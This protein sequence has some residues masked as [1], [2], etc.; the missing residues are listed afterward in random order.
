LCGFRRLGSDAALRTRTRID[1]ASPPERCV[2]AQSL[3]RRP[4][5]SDRAVAAPPSGLG[6]GRCSA[7]LWTRTG[8]LQRPSRFA[9]AAP[10][11]CSPK[12]P[13]CIRYHASPRPQQGSTPNPPSS[14]RPQMRTPPRPVALAPPA[15]LLRPCCACELGSSHRVVC[16][17]R[18]LRTPSPSRCVC[19]ATWSRAEG[20]WLKVCGNGVCRKHDIQ[21]GAAETTCGIRCQVGIPRQKNLH[22][23]AMTK[24]QKN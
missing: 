16:F 15:S 24:S 12:H 13:P 19:G 11:H 20:A 10:P 2:P 17:H 3:Q 23:P 14:A 9:Q 21:Q 4:L 5:D 22:Q 1:R 7:A 18:M 6:Q 8:P